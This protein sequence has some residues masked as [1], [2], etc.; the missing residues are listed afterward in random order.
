MAP[1]TSYEMLNFLRWLSNNPRIQR[2]DYISSRDLLHLVNEF[3]NGSL[4]GNGYRIELWRVGF[5]MLLEG[6][7]A[8][9]DYSAARKVLE[10][11]FFTKQLSPVTGY[12]MLNFLEWLSAE[13]PEI[14]T[15]NE[16]PDT[17]LLQLVDE[18][19]NGKLEKNSYLKSQWRSSFQILL[20]TGDTWKGYDLARR[21][22]KRLKKG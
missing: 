2:L 6:N 22:L 16:L 15:L 18:F 5:E 19:D 11:L 4:Y 8:L 20:K 21:E 13:H 3:E 1:I 7:D 10:G 9:D 12:E 17:D 14:Q